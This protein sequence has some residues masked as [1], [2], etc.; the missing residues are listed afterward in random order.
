MP[1]GR[2]VIV[3][4]TELSRERPRVVILGGG[5]GGLDAAKALRRAPVD[6]ILIDRRNHHLFQP[7]LYQVATASLSPADIATPIRKI[8]SRQR[9]VQVILAEARAVDTARRRVLLSE[10]KLEY[11][12]LVVAT[13]ATHS[14]FGHDEWSPLAPGLKTIEDATEIRRRFLIAFEAAEVEKDPEARRA[15]L[16]FVVVGGG[17][18]G[19]EL[20][21]A[22]AEIARTEIPR[23]FRAIDTTTTRVILIEGQPRLLAAFPE[24]SSRAAQQQLEQLGVEV[25]LN[26]TVTQVDQNGVMVG[27]R[28]IDAACVLWAAGV[29]ASPLG[30]TLGAPTDRAGRVQVQEDLS[31]PGRPEVFVIGDLAT[32]Q[33][34]KTGKPVP[35]VA[36]AAKQ[37]GD[38]VG[39]LIAREA[40]A[41]QE[42][43]P[44]PARAPFQYKDTGSLATIGRNRA[45]AAL[46]RFRFSG[47]PAWLLWAVAHILFLVSFRNRVAVAFSWAWT[48]LFHDRGARLITGDSHLKVKSLRDLDQ[49]ELE[50]ATATTSPA[51]RRRTAARS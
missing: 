40:A 29:R 11:D 31:L 5:F 44:A 35:G 6:V 21:G 22:M 25:M 3:S 26:S 30:Q 38:Y 46:G 9:N 47:L 48:Y 12:Y 34:R 45:V 43:R 8:L 51:P 49:P 17:P 16:T 14:Y 37:M 39:R 24:E 28:R 23:D 41:R 42:G 27:D 19:V 33:D 32:A 15:Q 4:S 36:P 13:G 50:E 10:G 20:A 7:L 1:A 18:T 2:E